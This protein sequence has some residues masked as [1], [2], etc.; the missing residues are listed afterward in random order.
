[1]SLTGSLG[2]AQ[3]PHRLA[4]PTTCTAASHLPHPRRIQIILRLGRSPDRFSISLWVDGDV[5]ERLSHRCQ[6]TTMIEQYMLRSVS[7]YLQR[8]RVMQRRVECV[9][10]SAFFPVVIHSPCLPRAMEISCDST[11]EIFVWN[12][13]THAHPD[14]SKYQPWKQF[15]VSSARFPLH[16]RDYLHVRH[17]H[18]SGRRATISESAMPC[19]G[20]R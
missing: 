1:M 7:S 15:L 14:A 18:I 8:D 3:T 12:R 11:A 10:M 20:Y 17:V 13:A 2:C 16:R 5:T 9:Y 19:R 4:M 6:R